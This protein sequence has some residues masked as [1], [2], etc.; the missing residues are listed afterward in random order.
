VTRHEAFEIGKRAG[1]AAKHGDWSLVRHL[2]GFIPND[3]GLTSNSLKS[4]YNR[5]Y[6]ATAQPKGLR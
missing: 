5:G 6:Q 4:A 3:N 1:T 2:K